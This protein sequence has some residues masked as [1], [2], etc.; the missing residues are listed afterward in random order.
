[1]TA[2]AKFR[3]CSVIILS[4]SLINRQCHI[5]R[6]LVPSALVTHLPWD[7]WALLARCCT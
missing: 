7:L 5:G 1:V 4:W 6:S 2:V 3:F